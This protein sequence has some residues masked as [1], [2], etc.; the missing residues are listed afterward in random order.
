MGSII[1]SLFGGW[2]AYLVVGAL[3][4][5]GAAFAT[6]ELDANHYDAIIAQDN[7]QSALDRKAVSDAATTAAEKNMADLQAQIATLQADSAARYKDLQDASSQNDQLRSAVSAGTQRLSIATVANP[8]GSCGL[9]K[10]G[11]TGG[12]VHGP[13]RSVIDPAAAGRIVAIANDGDTA[14]RKL[15]ACQSYVRTVAGLTDPPTQ[16]K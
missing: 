3:A 4:A 9:S 1:S 13:D 11:A 14:I 5:A 12:V 7:E 6:H 10:A 15:A 2:M 8:G 16:P